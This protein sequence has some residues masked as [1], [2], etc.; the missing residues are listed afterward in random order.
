VWRDCG[1][2]FYAQLS[3]PTD[4]APSSSGDLYV[5]DTRNHSTRKINPEGVISTVAG[6][7]AVGTSADSTLATVAMLYLPYWVAYHDASKT[8][9][10]ADTYNH[11][12]KKVINP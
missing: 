4:I 1:P 10:I 8:L 3:F 11:Q 6:T 9:Y 12:I 5:A 7:G 2:A